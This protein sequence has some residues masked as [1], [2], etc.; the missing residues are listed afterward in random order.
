MAERLLIDTDTASDDAV[1]LIMALRHS[2]VE[3]EAITVVA[4]NVALDQAVQNALYTVELCG[5][6]VPVFGGLTGP[7]LRDLEDAT[8]TH[9]DD[10]F[11]DIGLDLSGRVPTYGHAVD[12][13]TETIMANRGEITLVTLGPLSNVA[14]ALLRTP[15]IA[16]AV[17]RCVVMGGAGRGPGNVTPL[18]E[19]NLWADPEAA[20]IVC[21][22]GLPLTLVGWDISVAS[23]MLSAHDASRIR[24]LGSDLARFAIDIQATVEKFSRDVSGLDGFDLPDPMAMAVAIDPGIATTERHHVDVAFGDG[25]DRGKDIVDWL[26]ATGLGANA[27]VV[28]SVSRRRFIT[29]LEETLS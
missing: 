8:D 4:G 24:N 22:S 10:G 20:R 9:G 19:Y 18:A 13:I 6:S 26:D 14:T 3:V 1:A 12:V 23:A 2:D 17:K 27:D 21:R 15:D 29:M 25:R 16:T 11:G 28:T 5:S 7:L